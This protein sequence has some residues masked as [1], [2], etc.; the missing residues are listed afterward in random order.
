M[1]K[2]CGAKVLVY[3]TPVWVVGTYDSNGKPNA[4]TVA[5]GGVCC[6]KPPCVTVSLRKA[7]YTYQSILDRKAFTVNIPS[8]AHLKEADYMGIA[9]GRDVNKFEKTGLTSVKAEFVDAPYIKEFPVVLECKLVNVT[10]L[11]LHTMFVGE[12]IDVKADESVIGENGKPSIESVKPFLYDT[13]TMGYFC[14]GSK[15]GQGFEDGKK[16]D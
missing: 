4:M 11:G 14:T 6:S 12:I 7:T 1:K 15:I 16:V 10:E 2:S 3:P 13:G 8:V 5:W 9:S